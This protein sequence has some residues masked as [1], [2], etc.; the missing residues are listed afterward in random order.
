LP[1]PKA[2]PAKPSRGFRKGTEMRNKHAGNCYQCG[3]LVEAGTGHF[4][5]HEGGWRVKHANHPGQGRITCRMVMTPEE[6]GLEMAALM[7]VNQGC[8]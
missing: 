7:N 5:R 6:V 8:E 4:E 2:M 1:A 3:H